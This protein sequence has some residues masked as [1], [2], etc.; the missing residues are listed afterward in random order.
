MRLAQV[1]ES[2]EPENRLWYTSEDAEP[3][4][5]RCWFDLEGVLVRDVGAEVDQTHLVELIEVAKDDSIIRDL[6]EQ[7]FAHLPSS[8]LLFIPTQTLLLGVW[9]ALS[10]ITTEECVSAVDNVLA[11]D[12]ITIVASVVFV[13]HL[14]LQVHIPSPRSQRLRWYGCL[15]CEQ[16]VTPLRTESAGKSHE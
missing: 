8:P 16:V 10:V 6:W 4:S 5:E 15:I 14:I 1:W 13:N 7:L 11:I 2:Q 3:G 9:S 12:P